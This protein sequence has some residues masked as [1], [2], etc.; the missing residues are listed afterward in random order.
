MYCLTYAIDI[1]FMHFPLERPF[2][3]CCVEKLIGI[4]CENQTGHTNTLSGH[5]TEI[6]LLNTRHI[7]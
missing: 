4:C 3:E 1:Q 5:N 7:Q 2:I 6:G